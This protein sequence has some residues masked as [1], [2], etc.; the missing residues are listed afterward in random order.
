MKGPILAQT[1]QP[2]TKGHSLAHDDDGGAAVR[3]NIC[4]YGRSSWRGSTRQIKQSSFKELLFALI[5][6]INGMTWMRLDILLFNI[7]NVSIYESYRLHVGTL[8][9]SDPQC[10]NNWFD[11]VDDSC[12]LS[13][14]RIE[15]PQKALHSAITCANTA[16][17]IIWVIAVWTNC[18][19]CE[20]EKCNMQQTWLSAVCEKFKSIGST[21]GLL[22][23]Q[24]AEVSHMEVFLISISASWD[25]F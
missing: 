17:N 6:V 20:P 21:I 16:T 13:N 10:E 15:T 14:H 1:P 18:V 9:T 7:F 8:H 5:A 23:W 25:Y 12:H 22:K 19:F 4:I 3:A 24:V 2:V 11:L